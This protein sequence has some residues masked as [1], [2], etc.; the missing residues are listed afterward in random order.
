[1][2]KTKGWEKKVPHTYVI[3]CGMIFLAFLATYLVPAGVYERIKDPLTGRQIIDVTSFRSV[4]NTPVK[5]FSLKGFNLFTSI[6]EGLKQSSAIVFF[7]F[8]V[9]GSFNVIQKTG[10]IDSAI[11]KIALR[12]K[13]TSIVIIPILLFIFSV[14]GV[15]MG[16]AAEAIPFIPLGI[17]LARA[18]GYDAMVGMTII[19]LG[20]GVGFVGGFVNPF[21]VGLAQSIAQLPIYS[22]MGYRIAVYIVLY[23]VT[24]FYIIK[25]ANMIKKDPEKSIVRELEIKEKSDF[26]FSDLPKFTI[27]HKL[28]LLSFFI[29][30]SVIIYGVLKHKWDI[31]E[32]SGAFLAMA[33]VSTIVAKRSPSQAACDFL[34]GAASVAFGAL[35]VGFGRA[36]LLVLQ[37]GQIIDSI[38]FYVSSYISLLPSYIAVL[39]MYLSQVL[40]NTLIPSGTGQ[41]AATMPIMAPLSDMLGISRQTAVLAFQYGDGFTSYIIPTGSSIMSYLAVAKI[42][43]D[44]WLKWMGP[45]MGIWLF[46]GAI[47]VLIAHLIGY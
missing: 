5:L 6:I 46:I 22:G 18:V 39:L 21:T 8:L 13:N 34:E 20:A 14:G 30:F 3:I 43:Y 29:G 10:A 41:A 31:E 15:T 4:P 35:V 45:L 27:S 42:S 9:C 1:M 26:N 17:M 33:V 40:T 38:L 23:L 11:G 25:Y 32:L 7:T 36:I 47:A 37:Q 12:V 2:E 19:G 28:V 16:M 44:K 24:C